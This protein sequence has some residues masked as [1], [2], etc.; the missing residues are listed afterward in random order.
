MDGDKLLLVIR[1]KFSEGI[2]E[3]SYAYSRMTRAPTL[4][5]LLTCLGRCNHIAEF[6][7]AILDAKISYLFHMNKNIL[8]N[9]L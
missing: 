1:S 6:D 4:L 2:Y 8:K 9:K 5:D 7:V 3:L